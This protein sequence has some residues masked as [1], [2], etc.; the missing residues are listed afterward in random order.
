MKELN[1]PWYLQAG[2]DQ[3]VAVSTRIR[4]ARNLANFPFPSRLDESESER[5]L[6]IV[7]DAFN[8]LENADQFHSVLAENMNSNSIKIMEERGILDANNLKKSAVLIRNDGKLACAVNSSD[9]LRLISFASG[10]DFDQ[11]FFQTKS[12]DD[13]LQKII[14]FAA[15]YD[16][17]YLNTSILDSGSGMKLSVRLHLPALSE[18]GRIQSLLSELSEKNINLLASFGPGGSENVSGENLNG[19]SLGAFYDLCSKQSTEGSE[20]DQITAISSECKK[21][22]DAERKARS[23]LLKKEP[24]F[25]KNFMYRAVYLAKS[26]VFLSKRESIEI[27]SGVKLGKDLK[28]LTGID[29]TNLCALLLRMQ[30]GHLEFV[31]DSEKFKFE[32]DLADDK[33]KKIKRLRAILLQEAFQDINLSI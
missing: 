11:A 14:Q 25:V 27:I 17:G 1:E 22:I 4:L 29:D 26:S 10:F 9:H 12:T 2:T 7:I 6:S 5:I 24:S 13:E 23:E 32:K 3:D 8:H 30:E 20:F 16:F 31:L 19:T 15:S 21:I 28:L 33:N 18:N